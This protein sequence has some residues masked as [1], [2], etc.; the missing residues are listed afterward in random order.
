[1][2][3]TERSIYDKNLRFKQLDGCAGF[4]E[5]LQE[6]YDELIAAGHTVRDIKFF[7]YKDGYDAIILY[8][9]KQESIYE[10]R[11]VTVF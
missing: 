6:C 10:K 11:G 1:M 9:E 7:A 8:T 2:S 4:D 5:K 3:S